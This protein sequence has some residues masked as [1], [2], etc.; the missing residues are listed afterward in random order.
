[1]FSE[2][3][4]DYDIERIGREDSFRVPETV[5]AFANSSGGLLLCEGFDP[6]R[7]IPSGIPCVVEA[8]GKIYVPPLAWHKKPATLNGRV[9]RRIE[10]QNVISGLRSRII[11]ARD[12]NDP[13]K[14]DYPFKNITLS[15]KSITEFQARV[16]TLNEGMKRFE[17]DEFL[18][19]T[20]AYSGE[21]MTFAGALMFGDILRV[22]AVLDYSGGHAEIQAVNIWDSYAEILPRLAA[23]LSSKCSE[24][25]RE[26]FINTI[27]HADYYSDKNINMFITSNP[28]KVFADNPGTIRGTIRNHRLAKMFA[29][30]GITS[31]LTRRNN[32]HGLEII[33]EYMPSFRLEE[34]MLSFRTSATLILEGK[35]G[36]PEPV[37]L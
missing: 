36:L 8:Y 16:T 20:G 10:G 23:P 14:D 15:E 6:V 3:Q 18:R 34:N 31:R 11:M 35:S 21:F 25:F 9:Y 22:R 13:S 24:A 12:S 1:M 28:P 26:L 4:N 27:L 7:L 37:M 5:Y 32:L 17:R 19:R 2:S 29:L 33:R 30:S